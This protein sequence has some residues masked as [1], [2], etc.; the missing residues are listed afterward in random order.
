MVQLS[1]DCFA[2]G[3]PLLSVDAVVA[4]LPSRL[5]VVEGS[6]TVSLLQADGRVLARD[7]AAPLPMPPFTNSAV[8][9]YGPR[10]AWRHAPGVLCP[11]EQRSQA[12]KAGRGDLGRE[13][14]VGWRMRELLPSS[15]APHP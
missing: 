12:L 3:E 1:G 2:F 4:L 13:G 8:D 5:G 7:I 10:R 9:G 6:E 15:E 11:S 14:R